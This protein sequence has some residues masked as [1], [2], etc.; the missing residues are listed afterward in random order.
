MND[1]EKEIRQRLKDNF[2]HYASKC[3]KIRTK[4][5]KVEPFILNKAQ[6]HIH[7]QVEL[8]KLLIGKIRAI[9]LKGRQQGCSTY[10][11]GRFFWRVT[12][13]FGSQA[14]IL[15]HALDATSN[16]YKMA[17]RFYENCPA[18][19]RPSI[20]TSNSKELLFGEL[21]SGYKVGTA[22]NKSVG[23]SS[24]IQYFHGS[25]AAFWS[26]ASDHAKGIMQ[27]IPGDKGTEIF[28]ESTANGVSNYFHEQWQAAE[29]GLS[30]YIPIFVPWFW[31]EEYVKQ[32]DVSRETLS[33]TQIES[34]LILNYD[35]SYEQINWRRNKIAELS[36]GG[37]NGEAAFAQEYPCSAQEAFLSSEDNVYITP[38]IATQ[39][40][41]YM[42]EVEKYGPLV[43]GVDP[44]R[45]GDDRTV[46]IKRQGRVVFDLQSYKKYD[47]MQ[48]AGICHNIILSDKPAKMFIDVC[49]LGAGVYD[50]L[51]ELGHE[52]IIVA[53]NSANSALNGNKY[54][55]KRAE[56]WGEMREYLL[57]LPVK[58]PDDSALLSDL[59]GLTYK[60][61]SKGRI[62]IERKEDLKKRGMRSPDC[63]DALALTFSY[64]VSSYLT[65]RNTKKDQARKIMQNSIKVDK[66]RTMI[67]QNLR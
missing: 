44:A 14:F 31:Q 54:S 41:K 27:A 11:E 67:N 9:I 19:I 35:L 2:E 57:D 40:A 64:P 28:I 5:G 51:K 60:V 32:L 34:D 24:T 52:D 42:G 25:E 33:I 12:H 3:L 55:N 49:G 47:T 63:A 61:D 58:I 1:R 39:A 50:R 13:S 56:M 46:I 26:N 45:F 10:I 7:E 48:V 62:I 30:E 20:R 37:T 22:E 43:V 66:I 38:E 36:V 29:A 6:K 16:L 4:K 21:D 65:N 8:Q 59:C 23:R 17:Q 18:I 53:V 15:T